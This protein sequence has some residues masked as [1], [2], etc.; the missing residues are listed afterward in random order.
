MY[1]LYTNSQRRDV[2]IIYLVSPV[3]FLLL[4]DYCPGARPDRGLERYTDEH[5]IDSDSRARLRIY[6]HAVSRR[7]AC[8]QHTYL[9]EQL[10]TLS[11]PH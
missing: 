5:P 7:E 1:K 3:A 10:L 9:K 8:L 2:A 6:E 4:H 11:D